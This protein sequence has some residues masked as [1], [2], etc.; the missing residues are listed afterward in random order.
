MVAFNFDP[1]GVFFHS[2]LDT[3]EQGYSAA[4]LGVMQEINKE[5]AAAYDYS[6]YIAAG[7]RPIEERAEDGGMIWS[8][9]ELLEVTIRTAEDG[10]MSLRKAF[11]VSVYHHWER[12]ALQWTGKTNEKHDRLVEFVESMGYA[13]HPKLRAVCDL[14]N[15]LK[16]ANEKWG[17]QLHRTWP[18]LFT[19]DFVPPSEGGWR[20]DWYEQ[21]ALSETNMSEI[22]DIV[23]AS[24]PVIRP[25]SA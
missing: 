20:T 16:H 4:T 9:D 18:E 1:R 8:N 13:A 23:R 17:V 10:L 19:P 22:F 2:G 5:K 15:L 7:G 6:R 14:T 12:S 11:A 21:V 25:I 3:I 24:G